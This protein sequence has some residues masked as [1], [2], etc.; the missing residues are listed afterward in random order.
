MIIAILTFS[1]VLATVLAAY[2]L[3]VLRPEKKFSG[4]LRDRVEIKTRRTIGSESLVKGVTHQTVRS[5]LVGKVVTW[6][7]RY[8]L[9]TT[10]RLIDS[11][12]LRTDPQW[13]IGGTAIALTC[14]VVV[15]QIANAGVAIS[16]VAGALTPFVPYVYIH[17]AARRRVN[18]FEEMFPDAIGLMARALRAGHAFTATLTMVSDELDEPIKSEFRGLYEQHNYGLPLTQVMRTFATRIPLIDVRFFCTAVLTHRETGGNLA[19]VLDNLANV[20]RDRFRVRRQLKVLTAQGRL[21]GWILGC[22]PVVLGGA[23]YLMNPEQMQAFVRDPMGLRMFELAVGLQVVG[24][25]SIRRIVDV[26]Y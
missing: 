14:V 17:H 8:A 23:L 1:F 9:A 19:E 25:F 6:H 22:L 2:W 3:L 5:G 16:V 21:T 11:A 4:K 7:R 15:L 13:L 10:A 12:G 24:L 26:D 18:Q 20:M